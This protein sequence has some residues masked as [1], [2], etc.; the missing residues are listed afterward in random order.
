MLTTPAIAEG[1]AARAHFI[2]SVRSITLF[3]SNCLESQA[4]TGVPAPTCST[5]G[6]PVRTIV[7]T[8]DEHRFLL[9]GMSATLRVL[10]VVHCYQ[11]DAETIELISARK[12]TRSERAQY[13]ARW[14]K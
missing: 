11:R 4:D 2:V 12:A 10:V 5:H 3:V 9:I 7:F 6:V 1:R 14:L 13:G 8:I